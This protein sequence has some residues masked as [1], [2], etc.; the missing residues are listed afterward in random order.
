MQ[1]CFM[2]TSDQFG[3]RSPDVSYGQSLFEELAEAVKLSDAYISQIESGK[4]QGTTDVMKRIA[5]ILQV[6]VDDII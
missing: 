2:L 4:R 6:T 5:A 3:A 1:R